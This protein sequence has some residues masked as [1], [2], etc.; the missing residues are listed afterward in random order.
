MSAD[1]PVQNE[2]NNG[3]TKEDKLM[4]MLAHLLMIFTGFIAPLVIYLVKKDESAYVGKQCKEALNFCI[5]VALAFFALFVVTVIFG[6]IPFLGWVIG[7]LA[8][9]SYI[10]ISI[11]SLIMIIIACLRTSEGMDYAYPFNLRLIK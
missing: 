6:W 8:V 1:A 9:L 4:A 10:G 7:V 5:S 2:N 3:P 11:Y